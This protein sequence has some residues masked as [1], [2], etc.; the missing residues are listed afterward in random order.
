MCCSA[1]LSRAASAAT[2]NALHN[3]SLLQLTLGNSTDAVCGKVCVSR[4]NASQTTQILVAL[5]LPL[6]YQIAV[7]NLLFDAKLVQLSGDGFS[8]VEQIINVPS[9]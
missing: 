5:L 1:S 2:V 4:L 3:S 9:K 8:S 6:G 7:S